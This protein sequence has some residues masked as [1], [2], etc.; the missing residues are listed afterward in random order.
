TNAAAGNDP[1]LDENRER[2]NELLELAAKSDALA[3]YFR[4]AEKYSGMLM[5]ARE[6]ILMPMLE[7]VEFRRPTEEQ[8]RSILK[9]PGAYEL[10]VPTQA[11]SQLHEREAELFRQWAGREP[12]PTTFISRKGK[13]RARNAF[14]HWLT[15]YLGDL[16]G[17]EPNGNPHRKAIA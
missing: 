7:S 13:H 2:R 3:Q 16:F 14:V 9:F 1:D 15:S 6:K 4:N 10:I 12:L 8:R 11:L 17:T 5:P